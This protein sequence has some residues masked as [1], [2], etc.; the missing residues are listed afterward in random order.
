MEDKMTTTM[1]IKVPVLITYYNLGQAHDVA[2]LNWLKGPCRPFARDK[3]QFSCY[4]WML[5]WKECL[6]S[7]G[8]QFH[9]Y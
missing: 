5:L 9:G 1:L 7:D 4:S 3:E 2:W 8:Q 6:N